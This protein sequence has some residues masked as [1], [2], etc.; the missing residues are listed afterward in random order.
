MTANE[1]RCNPGYNNWQLYGLGVRL[2]WATYGVTSTSIYEY[3]EEISSSTPPTLPNLPNLVSK[4]DHQT[5]VRNM[6][7]M[8][9]QL[10]AHYTLMI[11]A[12]RTE[13]SLA[14]NTYWAVASV[15]G[16]GHIIEYNTNSF[17]INI[18]TYNHIIFVYIYM[19]N[20]NVS[21]V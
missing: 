1:H 16:R 9:Q 12:I 5:S 8:I 18:Y 2:L 3:L 15:C 7:T 10:I 13:W 14:V 20:I 21:C 11:D 17:C 4:R 19:H 6:S